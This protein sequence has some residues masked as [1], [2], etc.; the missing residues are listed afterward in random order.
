MTDTKTVKDRSRFAHLFSKPKFTEVTYVKDANVEHTVKFIPRVVEHTKWMMKA[1]YKQELAHLPVKPALKK[2]WDFVKEY[3]QYE[4]DESGK[5][6]VR[7]SR[8][9][10]WEGKGDCDCFTVFISTG[11]T[12][13]KEVKKIILRITKYGGKNFQH[14]Y[15][16]AV[17]ATGQMIP[18]DAV[19]KAWN[20]EEPFTQK[21][22]YVMEL[23]YLDGLDD[24]NQD[25]M[26]KLFD[27]LKKG[28][29]QNTALKEKLQNAGEKI[30]NAGSKVLHSVNRVN[31]ATV[32]LRNG[33]LA[34]M[35]LNTFKVSQRLKYAYL[36]DEQARQKGMDMAKF[37][38]LK[39]VR[40]KI[41]KVFYGAGGKPENLKEAILTGRGNANKAVSGLG[42]IPKDNI[43]QMSEKT[44]LPHLLGQELYYSE[45]MENLKELSGLGEPVTAVSV[46]TASGILATIAA[47][48]KQI[49]NLFPNEKAAGAED[50]QNVED[51]TETNPIT[52]PV[53]EFLPPP[54]EDSPPV[55]QNSTPVQRTMQT[56]PSQ[57]PPPA[58]EN[59]TPTE[60]TWWEKNKSWAKPTAIVAGSLAVIGV[61]YKVVSNQK[62]KEKKQ[63]DGIPKLKQKKN[64]SQK[65]KST[66]SKNTKKGFLS[67]KIQ[68]VKL[69]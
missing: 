17:L 3:I 1:F 21:E 38:K 59:K 8:R 57:T 64:K 67:G 56:D 4:K 6:Q 15:P 43:Y 7:S 20:Y 50:F 12:W 14:I 37:Q 30:K 10:F 25:E 53:E 35:K 33:V 45:N 52:P 65:S 34:A 49:G 23:N 55:E 27:F 40:E 58:G 18:M 9:L 31:P 41:E 13:L 46:G 29:P 19:A 24:S 11:M 2:L 68:K 16:I 62:K 36:T 42:Y 47:L 5:E 54:Q 48:L 44:P 28:T 69:M 66:K 61:G 63:V 22:D 32:L 51:A 26:G 39:T 60:Q